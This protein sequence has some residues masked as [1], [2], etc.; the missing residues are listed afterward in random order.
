MFHLEFKKNHQHPIDTRNLFN[1]V[2]NSCK[3]GRTPEME[4]SMTTRDLFNKESKPC[5]GE[6]SPENEAQEIKNSKLHFVRS[7]VRKEEKK[8]CTE[9]PENTEIKEKQS[10]Q[11][12]IAGLQDEVSKSNKHKP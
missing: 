1:D 6:T 10:L 2:S 12:K 7:H 3:D 9:V 4:V 5:R 11:A 8:Q